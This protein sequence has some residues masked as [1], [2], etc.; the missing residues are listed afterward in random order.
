MNAPLA[1]LY[2]S[3]QMQQLTASDERRREERRATSFA[4]W[5]QTSFGE[6]LEVRLTDI[7]PHGC[8]VT[9]NAGSM[10]QGAFVGIAIGT[11]APLK[12][13]I[14]WVRRDST[15]CESAGMEFLR[16]VPAEA[17]EWSA[18]IDIGA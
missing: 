4:A 14:R 6:R 15:G 9:S 10:R 3:A 13:V 2:S 8:C 1:R 18:L 7:S 17:H 11:G 12:A 5:L 16:A